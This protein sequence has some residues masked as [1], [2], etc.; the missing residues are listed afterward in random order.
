MSGVS[1]GKDRA[2]EAGRYV[3]TLRDSPM[4]VGQHSD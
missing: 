2:P 1:K 4:E 3:G